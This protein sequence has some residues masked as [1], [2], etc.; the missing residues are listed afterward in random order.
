[1]VN[2]QLGL[3]RGEAM[4]I[5]LRQGYMELVVTRG[6]TVRISCK[7]HCGNAFEIVLDEKTMQCV[8]ERAAQ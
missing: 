4:T 1:M 3:E 5:V 7:P 6:G 2:F 8:E